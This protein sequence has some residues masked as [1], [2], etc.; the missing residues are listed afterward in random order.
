MLELQCQP[1]GTSGVLFRSSIPFTFPEELGALVP[2]EHAG[3]NDIT[4]GPKKA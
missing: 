3:L 4:E 2:W 1:T